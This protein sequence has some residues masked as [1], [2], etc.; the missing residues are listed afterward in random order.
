MTEHA[1]NRYREGLRKVSRKMRK[2]TGKTKV[3]A[4]GQ[5]LFKLSVRGCNGEFACVE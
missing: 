5:L 4:V 3:A 1:T 2:D